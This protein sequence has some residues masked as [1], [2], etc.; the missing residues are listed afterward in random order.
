MKKIR[1]KTKFKELK[2]GSQM[3]IIILSVNIIALGGLLSFIS[4]YSARMQKK[5]AME[6]AQNLAYRY[7]NNVD[8]ELEIAMDAARTLAQSFQTIKFIDKENRRDYVNTVLK[9]IIIENPAFFGVSTC[10]EPNAF[11]GLDDKY[12]NTFGHDETGRFIPYF[13]RDSSEI[14]FEPL[15]DYEKQGIGNWYL[16]PKESLKETIINPFIYLVENKQTLMTSIVVPIIIDDK[17]VGVV[18]IDFLLE[19]L[20]KLTDTVSIYE[21]GYITILSNNGTFVTHPNKEVVGKIYAEI[22]PEIETT[23]SISKKI[24]NGE[25]YT[26]TNK[27]LVTGES[28]E[29]FIVPVKVGNSTDYWSVGVVVPTKTILAPVYLMQRVIIII[30]LIATIFLFIL[31]W[32]ISNNLSKIIRNIINQTQKLTQAALSGNL[33]ERSSTEGIHHELH[34][35]ING[36]NATLDALTKP[37]YI[38]ADYVAKISKGNLPPKITDEYNGDFD[39]LKNNI[40]QCID[41]INGLITEMVQLS[42]EHSNGEIDYQIPHEKFSGAYGI[43]CKS[44]NKLTLLHINVNKKSLACVAEFGA[45]NFNAEIEKFPGK[46]IFINETIDAVRK[47]LKDV[48]NDV[49]LL[50]DATMIDKF[51]IRAD[52]TKYKGDWAKLVSGLNKTLDVVV[53][54]V[55]WYE[56]MLDSIPFPISVTDME[57][58]WTFFNKPAEHVTGKFRKDWTGKQCNN[59][60][61]NICK[62]DK[63]GIAL[64]RKGEFVSSFIQPGL[65]KNF[66]VD[67]AY[68]VDKSGKQIGHIEIVQDITKQTKIAEYS[69]VEV[70]RLA[71]NL[72][73]L[74]F[75]NLNIDT[76]VAKADTYTQNEYQNFVTINNNLVKAQQAILSLIN[77]FDSLTV[78]AIA[79]KLQERAEETK[80]QGEFRKIVEGVNNILDAVIGPL[81]IAADYVAKI[82]IGDIPQVITDNYNGDFNN[83]KNNLNILINANKDIIQKARLVS[84]GDL[85][86]EL[87]KRSENDGLMIALTEM[88][89]NIGFVVKEVRFAAENVANGSAE[90][91]ISSQQMSQGASE[92]ASS[93]EE[94]SSSIEQMNANIAQNSENAKI[95]EQIAL[96]AALDI[97]EGYNSVD[98]TVNAMKK[99]AQKISI[100]GE[101]AERTDL[102]AIN[103]AIEAARA[104]EYGKGFAVVAAEV[105]KLAER[106]AKAA[107][108][109][110]ELSSSSVFVA[111]KSGIL[112]KEIVPQIEKTAKLVQEIAAASIEQNSGTNQMNMAINQLN[113]IAQINAAAS[114]EMATNSEELTS[115]AEQLKEVISF[116][117]V[118]DEDETESLVEKVTKKLTLKADVKK[119]NIKKD[120]TIFKK[121]LNNDEN[122]DSNY[123]KF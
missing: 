50:I 23:D 97:K 49:K 25:L 17:F 30:A 31:I 9:N 40:N 52:D 90:M 74:S 100:I 114:E 46:M 57:M 115:Q 60:G 119:K 102:L 86:V 85:S 35:I 113:Q 123:E 8:A 98:I 3:L 83:I 95:T 78:S 48:T 99:I 37:L 10:W 43:I 18:G 82:S 81:N 116:F 94:V 15:K 75:G 42:R 4:W 62:T 58:N 72:Q 96:K 111:E 67:T 93:I 27:S 105:R 22:A 69:K 24:K 117:N 26:F 112:L 121:G 47:N 63:C 11:D 77:D 64:M 13:Y 71:A 84:K 122:I 20:Q 36:M 5:S 21:T 110:D 51:E 92:Q 55:F 7:A 39:N 70:E 120:F 19:D 16:L 59:W 79:G 2:I 103:A 73:N 76:N 107:E 28:S 6:N 1:L 54:K 104:G 68:L 32:L 109:I 29:M 65:D 14:K 12:K 53:D 33:K 66:Q 80:H 61:A 89:K 38:T 87:E 106:S 44:L 41:S 118:K 91:S 101:I 108:E 88:V 34:P 45:G 56:Q